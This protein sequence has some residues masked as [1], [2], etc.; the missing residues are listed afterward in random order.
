MLDSKVCNYHL[1]QIND[2]SVEV[3][4]LQSVPIVEEFRDVFR[5]DLLRVPSER[6]IDFG[7]DNIPD[8]RPISI[9]PY[10]MAS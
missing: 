7:I 4:L 10:R 8:T 5:D 3:R 1:L 2:L 9:P 6:G